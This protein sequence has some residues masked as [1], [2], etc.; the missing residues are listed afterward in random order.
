MYPCVNDAKAII[1]IKAV[2]NITAISSGFVSNQPAG[3]AGLAASTADITV[4]QD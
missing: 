3:S 1:P 4:I 2:E